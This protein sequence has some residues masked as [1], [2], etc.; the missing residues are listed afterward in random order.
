MST[1][2]GFPGGGLTFTSVPDLFFAELLPQIDDLAE[3]KVTLHLIWLLQ[4]RKMEPLWVSHA[5]LERDGVLLQSL[6]CA[7]PE[8]RECLRDGL[9]KALERGT[10]LEVRGKGPTGPQRWYLLNTERGRRTLEQVRAGLLC[11]PDADLT[12]EERPLPQK[13]SIFVL[14]EQNIGPLQPIIADELEE[15]ERTY[16]QQWV[17]DAFRVAARNNARNWRYVHSVLERWRRQGRDE[18][19]RSDQRD[20]KR[21]LSGEY[22]EYRRH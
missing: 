14:Y 16:P 11:V 20:R 9:R 1:F 4:R 22:E 13:S 21:Y 3:L 19:N 8:P 2:T 17:E 6:R 5:E 18:P 15:A 12:A 10:L 7:G